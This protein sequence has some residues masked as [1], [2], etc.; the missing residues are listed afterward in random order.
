VRDKVKGPF[1]VIN[2]DDFYG[3]DSY[4]GLARFLTEKRGNPLELPL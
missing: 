1:A 4:Q 3:R 2:A